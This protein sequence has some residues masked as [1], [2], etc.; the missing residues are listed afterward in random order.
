MLTPYCPLAAASAAQ[1]FLIPMDGLPKFKEETD[2]PILY[3]P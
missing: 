1:K 3:V 2:G